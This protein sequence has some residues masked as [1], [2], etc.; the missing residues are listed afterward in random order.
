MVETEIY[1]HGCGQYFRVDFDTNKKGNHVVKCPT[2]QHEHC[3]V[4]ENGRITS[5]RWD[6]RNGSSYY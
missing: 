5:T 3:R 6:R 1:C 2:C 4:I